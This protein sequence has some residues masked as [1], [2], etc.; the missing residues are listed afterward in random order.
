MRNVRER[1]IDWNPM[2]LLVA[3]LL[4]LGLSACSEDAVQPPDTV[5]TEIHFGGSFANH[6]VYLEID[7]VPVVHAILGTPNMEGFLAAYKTSMTRSQHTFL[8]YWEAAGM[9]SGTLD[10]VEISIG[11]SPAY[12]I[13]FGL[14]SDTLLH[15][16]QDRQIHYLENPN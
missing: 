4:T 13:G 16:V 8:I 14:N 7:H 6:R 12:W 5:P 11:S 15:F 3:L 1:V 2:R 9:A 10:T